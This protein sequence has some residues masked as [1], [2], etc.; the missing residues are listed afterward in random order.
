METLINPNQIRDGGSG[1][2]TKILN[3]AQT[4]TLDRDGSN[5]SYFT[6]SDFFSLGSTV[7]KGIL[8]LTLN[9]KTIKPMLDSSNWEMNIKL[10]FNSLSKQRQGII[11]PV[12]DMC[13]IHLETYNYNKISLLLSTISDQYNHSIQPAS[14]FTIETDIWYWIKFSFD[15]EKYTLKIS[16]DGI[17]YTILTEVSDDKK[18]T[19]SEIRYARSYPTGRSLDGVIDLEETNIKINGEYWWKGVVTL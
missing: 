5:L 11:S 2:A 10:K 9:T 12:I 14:D 15:S 13:F 6:D 19:F 7:D 18:P 1:E 16:T 17:N 4:G 3:V 8:S